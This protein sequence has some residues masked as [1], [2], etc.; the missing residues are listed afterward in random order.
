MVEVV[1][2]PRNSNRVATTEASKKVVKGKSVLIHRVIARSGV[3]IVV[4]E[5]ERRSGM[6]EFEKKRDMG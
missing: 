1:T 3:T 6:K 4:T 5:K 2:K